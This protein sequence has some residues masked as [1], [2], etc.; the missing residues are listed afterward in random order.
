G[1]S[2][3]GKELI[4]NA[5][6]QNSPRKDFRFLPINCAA[7]PAD[8]LESELF[9]HER[10]AFTGAVQRKQGKFEL[11]DRG[12]LFVEGI[13]ERP[14]PLQA[15]LLRA[16][17]D[18]TFMRVGGTETITVDVRILAATNSDLEARVAAGTFRSDLYYRLKVVTIH[19]PPLR[20][21]TQDIPMLTHRFF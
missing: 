15:T 19:V 9:G 10:G 14:L 6:H 1:E 8:I 3:T 4:A 17:E 7:I 12:T 13:G 18:R 20:D 2:G 16:L 21:R 5:L 11:A